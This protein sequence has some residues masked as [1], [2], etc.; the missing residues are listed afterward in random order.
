[1]IDIVEDYAV[2]LLTLVRAAIIVV[3][4]PRP[5]SPSIPSIAPKPLLV[6]VMLHSLDIETRTLIARLQ[7]YHNQ[8]ASQR[9]YRLRGVGMLQ[10]CSALP[11]SIGTGPPS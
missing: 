5:T 8:P 7:L 2:R 4:A 10:R 1:M 9:G 11:A 6:V 3:S